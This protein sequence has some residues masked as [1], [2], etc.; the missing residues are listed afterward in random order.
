MI[1]Q[2]RIQEWLRLYLDHIREVTPEV[3][4]SQ[5][6][7]YKFRAV[8]NFQKH[9]DLGAQNFAEMLDRAIEHNNLSVGSW[10]FPRKMLLI[11][12]KE[13][14]DRT[15][16]ALAT[17]YDEK[18]SVSSR[19]DAVEE[20]FDVL[21][22]ERNA[23]LNEEAH[24][25][26]GLRFLS[27]LL[28]YRYPDVHDALKPREW[29]SFC[30]FI[31]PDFGIPNGTLSGAQYEAFHPYTESLRIAIKELPEVDDLRIRLTE[32]LTFKDE[33]FHWMTQDVIY[34]TSRR[35][36]KGKVEDVGADD[37][38]VE[39]K[40][41][42]SEEEGE[43]EP[44]TI[45]DRFTYEEDLEQFVIDNLARAPF[46]MNLRLY[47]DKNG[48]SGQQ[49]PTEFGPIDVLTVDENGNYVVIELKRDLV[50]EK[51]VGQVA[52]YMQW[53]E[54]NLALK[55]GKTVRG[56]VMAY[57]G[58]KSLVSALGALRFPVTVVYYNLQLNLS[59]ANE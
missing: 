3:H 53:V 26:M 30:N 29:K 38:G 28:S 6:E 59:L 57:R 27:L 45:D 46:G 42:V 31:D 56:V 10:Y 5:E 34:V 7:G 35:I 1:K 19:I 32:G 23:R 47:A 33:Q 51:V 18:Q 21:M 36:A 44:A 17:L 49:Y 52:K 22:A 14:T 48:R 16:S 50:T 24:H 9:F 12:A 13:E 54:Q 40:D 39:K 43:R 8:D 58:N 4:V 15:R 20:I 25:F 11:F 37:F 2:Q 55:E 41:E